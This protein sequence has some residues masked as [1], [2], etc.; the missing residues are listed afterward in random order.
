MNNIRQF[1]SKQLLRNQYINRNEVFEI[2]SQRPSSF[3]FLSGDTFLAF[4]NYT[5]FQ[6]SSKNAFDSFDRNTHKNIVSIEVDFVRKSSDFTSLL[7]WLEGFETKPVIVIHNGDIPPNSSKMNELQQISSHIYMVNVIQENSSL[8]AIPIGLENLHYMNNG[9]IADFQRFR[10]HALP[11][12]NRKPVILGG[13]NIETNLASRKTL[14]Q[15]LS[16]SRHGFIEKRIE[17][18]SFRA[19]MTQ[20]MFVASPPG[21][22]M[23]CHRT[24]ESIYLGAVPIVEKG[25]LANSL[26]E[27]LPI[28]AVSDWSE[29]LDLSDAELVELYFETKSKTIDKAFM[30]YWVEQINNSFLF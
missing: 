18:S 21:N 13:F 20:S 6:N 25:K 11:Q 14:A 19:L 28:V 30:P 1:L 7:N 2:F 8:S 24:W 3:P 10:E 27:S 9:R 23:D 26:I 15:K 16:K 22:G 5:I 17:P 12:E 29:V 4:A